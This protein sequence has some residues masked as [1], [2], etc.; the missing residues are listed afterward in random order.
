[1]LGICEG[2]AIGMI[3]KKEIKAL[4]QEFKILQK[5]I[6]AYDKIVIYRHV[7]PDYDAL[8]SQ[9]GLATWIKDNYPGKEVHYV[10][11]T[12]KEMVEKGLFP[13]PE[14]LP[15]EWY[16][17]NEHLA[18]T[19]DVSD[20]PRISDNHISFAKEVIKLDHHPLPE[21]EKQ[22]GDILI[23][24]PDRPAAAEIVALFALS[25][26]KKLILS[27][28]A[29]TYLYIGIFGDT[30]GFRYQDTDGA[31][32]RVAGSLID[33]GVKQNG[34]VS[35][36]DQRDERQ[37]H[38][39]QYVLNHFKVTEKGT[40]YYIF[41]KDAEEEL[42]MG[43]DE[44]NLFINV[45]RGMKGVKVACSITWNEKKQEYRVSLRSANTVIAPA[46]LLFDGGGHDFAAGCKLKSLEDLP[47]L[48]EALDNL[49]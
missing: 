49:K 39:L 4:H 22:F 2:K 18:I 19:V 33:I 26:K 40:A 5:K 43:S 6:E 30:G 32:M 12:Q 28:K 10:G 31:T 29:A 38:I 23:V 46:A 36:M 16:K 14:V 17:E 1:M 42:H 20:L 8:G 45:L 13:L 35:L 3:D 25:R 41:T 44:G 24:H 21:K 27:L 15:E 47:K 11:E 34:V 37:I 48:L 9:M 7:S